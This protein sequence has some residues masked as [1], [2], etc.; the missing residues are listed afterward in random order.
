[1]GDL[2][3]RVVDFLLA[4]AFV[5]ALLL[6][7]FMFHIW[8]NERKRD[9]SYKRK[10]T[11]EVLIPALILAIIFTAIILVFAETKEWFR[12]NADVVWAFLPFG[13]SFILEH[14]AAV[15][16]SVAILA[17]VVVVWRG[18]YVVCLHLVFICDQLVS[19]E[20]RLT[21]IFQALKEH[22]RVE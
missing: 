7:I 19:V 16:V 6:I 10:E 22:Q 8:V 20:K 12:N 14:F 9:T 1:M 17:V 11:K 5:Y 2:L 4:V 13:F 18:L 21:E 15:A 3:L